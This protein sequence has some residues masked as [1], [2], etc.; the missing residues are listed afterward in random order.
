MSK[1][2]TLPNIKINN[3]LGTI[4]IIEVSIKGKIHQCIQ[5]SY[6]SDC[7]KISS[8]KQILQGKIKKRVT[9]YDRYGN[10]YD[11]YNI[12]NT[13]KGIHIGCQYIHSSV[14]NKLKTLLLG[15]NIEAVKK[16]FSLTSFNSNDL[17]RISIINE[18]VYR[19]GV[20]SC[21]YFPLREDYVLL[22]D[23]KLVIQNN[24]LSFINT[25]YKRGNILRLNVARKIY[26][27][28]KGNIISVG[29]QGIPSSTLIQLKQYFKIK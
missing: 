3:N 13:S 12:T 21:I 20:F 10:K 14:V 27:N 26:R 28:Y 5:F 6:R 7:I 11:T 17:R 29:C 1:I 18:K 15:T 22:N 23:V 8:V 16:Q 2:I 24:K 4:G 9:T 25:Y 19:K